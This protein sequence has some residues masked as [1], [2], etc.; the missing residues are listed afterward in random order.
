M[1]T[2]MRREELGR[3]CFARIARCVAL[4][5][6]SF[7]HCFI[8]KFGNWVLSVVDL[9]ASSDPFFVVLTHPAFMGLVEIIVSKVGDTVRSADR[10]IFFSI[11][12]FY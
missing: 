2:Q 3:L 5:F 8:S 10:D 1:P 4:N 11:D 12:L 9:F 7:F 6:S